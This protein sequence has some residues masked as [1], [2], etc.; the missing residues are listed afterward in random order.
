MSVPTGYEAGRVDRREFVANRQ[1]SADLA[2][3]LRTHDTAYEWAASL[4]QPHAMRGRAPVYVA[5]LPVAGIVV[6]VRHSWHGGLLAPI[7]GDRFRLPTRA[8]CELE[9]ARQL[10]NAGIGTPEVLSLIHI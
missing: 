2:E 1:A 5:T 9:L 6:V 10:A 8:P 4:P 3:I 7:T